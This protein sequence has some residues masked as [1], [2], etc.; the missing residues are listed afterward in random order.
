MVLTS[1]KSCR[2]ARGYSLRQLAGL[3]GVDFT[4]I[5]RLE[6]GREAQERTTHKLAKALG[7]EPTALVAVEQPAPVIE[8]IQTP[9]VVNNPTRSR[10]SKQSAVNSFWV[11]EQGHEDGDP[12]R[13]D[14]QDEAER[15]K[16][17]LG[18]ARVY[19][20]A[21]KNDAREQHRAFLVR[22]ARGHDAW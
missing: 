12:F 15:L 22:V 18:R 21:S 16:K 3:S 1:L 7:V 2:L 11:I 10:A 17:R 8:N 19:E 6:H 9:T 20:A 4:T 14:S 13:A 5:D